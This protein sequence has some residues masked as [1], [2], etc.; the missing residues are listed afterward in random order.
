MWYKIRL[1]ALSLG[2]GFK[3][4]LSGRIHKEVFK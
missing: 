3:P 2:K 1:L 4:E